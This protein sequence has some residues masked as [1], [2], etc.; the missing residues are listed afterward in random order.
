MILQKERENLELFSFIFG[1][2][3]GSFLNVLIL[4]LPLKQNFVT[5][6]SKCPSC[7]HIISWYYNIP[8]I[9][10]LILRAKCAYCK[11]KISSQYF[12]VELLTA[13]ITSKL[14]LGP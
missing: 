1:A 10:F 14:K 4:K 13:F 7:N 11:A 6:R 5:T 12:I 3:I 2:I 9:S 8:L